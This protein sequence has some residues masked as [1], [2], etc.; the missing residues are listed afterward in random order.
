LEDAA[1]LTTL[2]FSSSSDPL[3]QIV[4]QFPGPSAPFRQVQIRGLKEGTTIIEAGDRKGVKARLEVAVKAL[5]V[6]R[7]AFYSVS[8]TAG[9]RSTRPM[10]DVAAIVEG[11]NKRYFPQAN[12]WLQAASS[13]ALK[14]NYNLGNRLDWAERRMFRRLPPGPLR[15]GLYR[16]GGPGPLL[17]PGEDDASARLRVLLREGDPYADFH[18]Y[19]VWK[20][21]SDRNVVAFQQDKNCVIQDFT[22]LPVY[23]AFAHELGHYLLGEDF[24][25]AQNPKDPYHSPRILDLIFASE[26][27]QSVRISK[28]QANKM[29]PS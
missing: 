27:L 2:N 26:Q 28:D 13:R 29:N 15:Y 22:G 10:S 19:F 1:G 23:L 6:I 11:S 21:G 16:P 18:V 5:K 3:V 12:I 7:V 25:A 20:I 9:H 24:F 17:W 14:I 8:D 4:D